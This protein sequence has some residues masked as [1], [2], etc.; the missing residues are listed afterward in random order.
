MYSYF[1]GVSYYD[2]KNAYIL[3]QI[4]ESMVDNKNSVI[5]EHDPETLR[6]LVGV[7]ACEETRLKRRIARIF[8]PRLFKFLVQVENKYP[9]FGILA[10]EKQKKE[11]G[12]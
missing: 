2:I 5:F 4:L 11:N 1:V 8:L 3:K 6:F 7:N 10:Y 12:A 9:Q